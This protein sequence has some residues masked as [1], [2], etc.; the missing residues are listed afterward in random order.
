MKASEV[1]KREIFVELFALLLFTSAVLYATFSLKSKTNDNLMDYDG[2]VTVLDD[3]NNSKLEI[4]SDGKG[5][6]SNGISY[7]VTNN[8]DKTVSYEIIINPSIH[9]E[10]VLKQMRV[11]LDDIFISDLTELERNQGGYVLAIRVLNPGYTKVHRIKYWYKLDSNKEI[12]NKE[13][14]FKYQ[15]KIV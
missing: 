4:L 13:I 1:L 11:S 5:L 14:D 3:K 12:L 6:D 10:S 15:I 9:D 7:T 8:R 2:V